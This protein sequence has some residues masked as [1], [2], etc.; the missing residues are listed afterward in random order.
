MKRLQYNKEG[1]K[2]L[3]DLALND[4]CFWRYQES[5][6]GGVIPVEHK[7]HE[8]VY[9]GE[10]PEYIEKGVS[11][12]GDPYRLLDYML[13]DYGGYITKQKDIDIVMFVGNLV[14]E[15]LDG[16]DI[17]EVVD[18]NDCW[19]SIDLQDFLKWCNNTEYEYEDKSIKELVSYVME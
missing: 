11:C 5:E 15:G 17:V 10:D 9:S 16:E 4:K 18:K 12:Y 7:S 13:D 19:Y 14:D 6:F 8:R 3:D 2:I 1:K